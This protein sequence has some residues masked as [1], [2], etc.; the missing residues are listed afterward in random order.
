[1]KR[2]L[3]ACA[4]AALSPLSLAAAA[5]P[6]A[7]AD[8]TQPN[9][10]RLQAPKDLNGY[11]PFTPPAT[12]AE[13]EKR[14]DYVRRQILVSQGLW[15][16]P[17]KTPLNAVIHGK[18]ERPEYT[19]EKVYFESAPGLFVTG[20]LYRPTNIKGKVPAVLFAHGHWQNARLSMESDAKLL[21]EIATGEERFEQGGR[22]R[23]QSM[24]VQLARM[25]CVVWQWDMLSD[26]DAVQFSRRTVH[27]FAKQR[28]EMNATENWGLYSPQAEAHLQSIMGLQTLNAVRSLDFVLSLPEVDPER[29]AITGASGGGTQTMLLA[30]IDPRVKLSFPAV[31]VSTAMQGGCTCENS[32]LLRVNTGNIEFAALFAPKPQGMTTANDWTKEM[33][34]KGFPELKQLYAT[35]GSPNNVMLQRGEHFPH[36][37]NAVTRSAFYTWLNKHFKLGFAEPVIE[38]DYEPLDREQLTVWDDKHPAPKADDADFERKLLKWLADDAEKQ[39]LLAAATNDELRKQVGGGVEV[40]I[41]RTFATA[42]DVD[43]QLNHKSK[44]DTYVE[45]TGVLRNK[46]YGEELPVVWL[47]PQK[48]NGRVVVWLDDA[49]KSSLYDTDGSVKPAVLQLVDGGATV[50]GAD[51]LFQGEFLKDGQPLTSTRTVANPREYAGYTLGYNHSLF[52]QRAHDVLTMIKYLRTAQVENHSKPASVC[53]AGFGSTGPIVAAARAVAGDSIDRVALDTKGFRFGKLLNYRD[54]QFLPG[55]A[56]YLD[57]PGLLLLSAPQPLWLAGEGKS[58]ALVAEVYRRTGKGEQLTSYTGEAQRQQ[59]AASEWLLK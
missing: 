53:V 51:L 45:M 24:C 33:S 23:F 47:Y 57:L 7:L 21:R 52:A 1:M 6:R 36:N 3:L 11:F 22:S 34:T 44:R 9:D 39:L 29:T 12:K 40:A 41:G 42:G 25:G 55:G 48:P 28:P 5:A 26:S 17:T 16:M 30:A 59:A 58:P 13:W 15:P 27:G 37:Y 19:V 20:N 56:K 43:W 38:R 8:G 31:M 35:L 4:I 32:S 54:P 18:I 46:T 14:A 2:F 50:L 49:G 10:V